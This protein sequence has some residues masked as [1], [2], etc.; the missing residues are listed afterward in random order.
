MAF[1]SSF[2]DHKCHVRKVSRF[3]K[4]KHV[5]VQ[6]RLR[7][8]NPNIE[9]PNVVKTQLTIITAKHVQLAFDDVGCVPT[10]RSGSIVTRLDL[11]PMI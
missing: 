11:F 5:F 8:L 9:H 1:N 2:I 6:I 10:S 3:K 4:L 7:D